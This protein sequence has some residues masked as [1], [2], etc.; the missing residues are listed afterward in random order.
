M[1]VWEAGDVSDGLAVTIARRRV[2]DAWRSW[3]GRTARLRA[4][5]RAVDIDSPDTHPPGVEDHCR[6]S[7]DLCLSGRQA[8]LVDGLALGYRRAE[9]ARMLGIS[10]GRV[11][12]LMH[13]ITT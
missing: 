3:T 7:V 2:I 11:S 9:L 1:A 5:R 10:A 6:P 12:Q 13:T 8:A 4:R